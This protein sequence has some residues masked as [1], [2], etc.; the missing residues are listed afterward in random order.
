[1]LFISASSL[2]AQKQNWISMGLYT[3]PSRTLK[4]FPTVEFFFFLIYLF[5]LTAQEVLKIGQS[6][7][8]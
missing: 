7:G 2:R 8:I 4:D 5:L 1:M 3:S 6:L